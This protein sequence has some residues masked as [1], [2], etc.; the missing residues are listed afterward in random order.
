VLGLNM[1]FPFP[2]KSIRSVGLLGVFCFCQFRFG[3]LFVFIVG[4]FLWVVDCKGFRLWVV[5]RVFFWVF[6]WASYVC[7]EALH[8]FLVY[9]EAYFFFFLISQNILRKRKKGRNP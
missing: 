6:G 7:S 1:L 8:A 2:L 9:V 3:S 5:F 4:C